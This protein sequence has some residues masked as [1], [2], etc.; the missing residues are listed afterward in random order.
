MTSL[1]RGIALSLGTFALTFGFAA[2]DRVSAAPPPGPAV[3][4]AVVPAAATVMPPAGAMPMAPGACCNPVGG[5]CC[6]PCQQPPD[7]CTCTSFKPVVNTSFRQQQVVGYHDVCRT[8]YKQEQ[9]C[10]TV[11]VTKVDCVTVDEGCYKMVWCPKVVTK[12][13][14]RV[15]YHQ[16]VRCRTVPFT[17]TQKVP[18][19]TT[20]CVPE[21]HVRY[22]PQTRT[23]VKPAC[24]TCPPVPS[25]AQP[26]PGCGYP[27]PL[28]SR[29]AGPIGGQAMA[30]IPSMPMQQ[31][32]MVMQQQGPIPMQQAGPISGPAGPD[33]R[34]KVVPQAAAPVGD[35][36]VAATGATSNPYVRARSAA[37]VW[38][39]NRGLTAR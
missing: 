7:I 8:C 24:P 14:P 25:C 3:G 15:E 30:S 34:M 33:A 2:V 9:Y 28:T 29:G 12:Q 16:Q 18:H 13:V 11:P 26:A 35:G 36:S 21:Y 22:V 20:H 39:T 6:P 10:E 32:P 1:H 38:Q 23:F 31:G 19:V 17:V 27:V 37:N 5:A 4:P